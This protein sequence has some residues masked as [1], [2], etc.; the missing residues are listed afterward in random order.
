VRVDLRGGWVLVSGQMVTVE[1]IV[2][3][4]AILVLLTNTVQ[5]GISPFVPKARY[6]AQ[7]R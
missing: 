7:K 1:G 4:V 5:D 3:Y 2:L 6:I